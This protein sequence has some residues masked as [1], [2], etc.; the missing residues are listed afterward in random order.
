MKAF[1]LATLFAAVS[2]FTSSPKTS[3][4]SKTALN[5]KQVPSK[6]EYCPCIPLS[7][8]PKPGKATSGVAGGLA[9]CI[10]VDSK[11]SVYALGDKCP[12]INQPL[13][14]GKVNAD[15]TIED[16]L[17]GTKFS[18]K[19]GDVVSWC[20]SGIGK[21]LGGA[22]TPIGVPVYPVRQRGGNIEVQVDVNAKYNFEANYWSGVLDAQGKDTGT[23]Y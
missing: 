23:Y 7:D 5:A 11:G 2:A 10:A 4:V 22:F 17:L 19:T 13:S 20:P 12:P 18:L 6:L 14:F 16:P 8:L 21:I 3:F 15:G 9:I 1:I